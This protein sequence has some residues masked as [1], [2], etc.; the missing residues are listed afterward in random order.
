[1]K[2]V[3]NQ[4]FLP[5]KLT[6]SVQRTKIKMQIELDFFNFSF[7]SNYTHTYIYVENYNAIEELHDHF[8]INPL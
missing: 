7:Y 2:E 6:Q 4:A 5:E 8:N 1:M 3:C